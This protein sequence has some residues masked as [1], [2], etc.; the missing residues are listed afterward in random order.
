M[1]FN[2]LMNEIFKEPFNMKG[3]WLQLNDKPGYGMEVIDDIEKNFPY[4]PGS[5][6]RPN[7][8]MQPS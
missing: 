1:T 8:K 5:F 3:G 6:K 4:S 7:P 2:P